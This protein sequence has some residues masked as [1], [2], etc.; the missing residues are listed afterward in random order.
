MKK[1]LLKLT[2]VVTAALSLTGCYFFPAEEELLDPPTVAV[3]DVAYSTYTAKTKTI[4]NKIIASGFVTSKSEYEASFPESGGTIKKIY[5]NA[6][7]FVEEGELLAELDTGN[8]PYLY[9]QQKLIVEKA[10]LT[11][12]ASG[13][14][15]SRLDYEM[16]QNTL[17]EYER[18]LQNSRLYAGMAGQVCFTE[19]MNPGSSVTAYKTIVKIIDPE[20]LFIKYNSTTLKAFP[21]GGDVT[22]TVEGEDFP[23]YVAKT[24]TEALEGL[25]DEYPH[26]AQDTTSIYCEFNDAL[27][28][29]LT[30]G[31]I[32]DITTVF[33]VHENAVVISKNLVKTDGERTY[34]TILDEN[35]NK[36]EVDVEVGITNA[37][38]AEILSGV[39]AGDK[40]VV[41]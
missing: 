32:A 38:E 17:E 8:L 27:P 14:A 5:V 3:E 15:S 20:N 25:Y 26:L 21:L 19:R 30:I 36:T 7:Q 1:H 40:I 6:G 4:E 11:Y 12:N 10:A 22:I 23:G 9:E 28:S 2:A 33:E 41:R 29:F 24:P 34:V 35:E 16:A 37:T 13:S 31:A 39:K 18:Q